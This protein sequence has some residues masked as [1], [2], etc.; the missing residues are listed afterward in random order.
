MTELDTLATTTTT[1]DYVHVHAAKL[2]IFF[3][4]WG[5]YRHAQ[6]SPLIA[7]IATAA[8]KVLRLSRVTAVNKKPKL[9][10]IDF[11]PVCV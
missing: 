9:S 5:G 2:W 6:D 11:P 3:S 10:S 7:A 4:F 8:H 1:L